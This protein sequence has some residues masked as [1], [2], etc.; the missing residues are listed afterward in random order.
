MGYLQ[1]HNDR[2]TF[3]QKQTGGLLLSIPWTAYTLHLLTSLLI[4]S[5]LLPR[6]GLAHLLRVLR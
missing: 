1:V 6:D 3:S 4:P 2:C 5:T